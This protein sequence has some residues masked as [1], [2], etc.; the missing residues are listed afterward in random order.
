MT[1]ELSIGLDI[2]GSWSRAALGDRHG[3]ILKRVA[4]PLEAGGSTSF[5]EHIERLVQSLVG[6]GIQSIKGIGVGAAGRLSLAK[7]SILFSPHAGLRDVGIRDHLEMRFGKPVTLLNDCV[8]AALA[9]KRVGAGVHYRDLVYVGIGTGIGG[10]II[11]GGRVLMGKD[12]NAHE[13]GHMIIDMEGKLP[14]ECGGWGHWEAYTSGS[15]IPKY[16]RLLARTFGQETPLVSKLAMSSADSKDI[17]DAL[18]S[19]DPFARHVV[20]ECASLNAM[21]LAN[22]TNLYDPEI[23]VIGGGV[24]LKNRNAV[25]SPLEAEVRKYAFNL[26]P[27]VV[28][29]PLGEDSP[30]IGSILSVF[31]PPS[32]RG[33]MPSSRTCP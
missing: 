21:A 33:L 15:G 29:T 11:S 4:I 9:E 12:G 1:E 7:G 20:A 31:G 16:A 25:V 14:C 30:L 23:I 13:I 8:M 5:E 2:G 32:E 24:A 18:A 6:D 26:P 28:A 17:F 22:L 27:R 3:N 19:G 10:G